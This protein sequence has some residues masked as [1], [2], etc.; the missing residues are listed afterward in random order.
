MIVLKEVN[1]AEKSW[2]ERDYLKNYNIDEC[3]IKTHSQTINN[4]VRWQYG[5]TSGKNKSWR[6]IENEMK[7]Q[8]NQ[9][10][11]LSEMGLIN[12]KKTAG[13]GIVDRDKF[14]AYFSREEN[15]DFLRKQLALYNPDLVICGGT[16]YYLNLLYDINYM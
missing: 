15:K 11:A 1:G 8:S 10:L 16:A 3:Y 14:D 9:N 12:L 4:L 2:D 5:I 6:E 13:C 7:I